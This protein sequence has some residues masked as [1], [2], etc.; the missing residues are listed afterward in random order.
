MPR[1]SEK[2]V[3]VRP[4]RATSRPS[5]KLAKAQPKF[6]HLPLPPELRDR[7]YKFVL[8]S[9]TGSFPVG[10]YT[11][12]IAK[13]RLSL[14]LVSKQTCL[15]AFSFF[16]RYNH[17]HF[18]DVDELTQFLK[19]I[20]YAR[21]HFVTHVTLHWIDDKAELACRALQRCPNLRC[22][23]IWLDISEVFERGLFRECTAF[24]RNMRG[25]EEV[26]FVGIDDERIDLA[27]PFDRARRIQSQNGFLE[28]EWSDLILELADLQH[29]M[30][31]LRLSKHASKADE[32]VDIFSPKKEQF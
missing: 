13:Q 19:N 29:R 20:G 23:D 11:S 12:R 15:E 28:Q 26:G 8:I 5:D 7:V 32:K 25:L 4:S 9:G 18:F 31:R 16:Y 21:R 30:M 2:S 24:F 14:L 22:I 17:F 6:K 1:K 10:E 3:A 27:Q